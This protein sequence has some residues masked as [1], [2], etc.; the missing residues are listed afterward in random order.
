VNKRQNSEG[1]ICPELIPIARHDEFCTPEH[2][3]PQRLVTPKFPSPTSGLPEQQTRELEERIDA[4]NELLLD[5]A[6]SNERPEEG[7]VKSFE[8][9]IGQSVEVILN[10]AGKVYK[11]SVHNQNEVKMTPSNPAKTMNTNF[12][13]DSKEQNK[14]TIWMK[15]VVFKWKMLVKRVF[16]NRKQPERTNKLVENNQDINSFE[17]GNLSGRVHLVGRDFVLIRNN[18][19]ETL[20]PLLKISSIKPHDRFAQPINEPELTDIDP[21]L[22][23]ALTFNFGETVA[24]SPELIEIFFKMTLPIFLLIYL[25]KMVKVTVEDE[26]LEGTLTEID[27]ESLIITIENGNKRIIPLRSIS[28]LLCK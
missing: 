3:C 27:N 10:C 5:L 8:G 18:K 14:L 12:S 9:L 4:A 2:C 19:E 23:R 26:E 6:L 7:R 11:Y 15:I 24:S 28:F 25:D 20:I 21:C 16:N 17:H 1:C 22:R 13:T